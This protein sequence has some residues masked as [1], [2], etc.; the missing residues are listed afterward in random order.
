MILND[1]VLDVSKFSLTHPAGAFLINKN[2]GRDISKYFDGGYVM[3][4]GSFLS[5]GIW[6]QKPWR[7]SF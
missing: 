4:N 5:K 6:A 3:E 7:H 2:V 1:L